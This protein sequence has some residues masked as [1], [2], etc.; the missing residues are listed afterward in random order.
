MIIG[1]TGKFCTGK[2]TAA[3]ILEEKGF[4]HLSLSDILREELT[5]QG[6]PITRD[7]LHALGD[8]LRAEHGAGVLAQRAIVRMHHGKN[9]VVTSIRNPG[10]VET[11]RKQPP[12][13]LICVDAPLEL[14]FKRLMERTDRK[15]DLSI[16]TPQDLELSERKEMESDPTKL[17]LHTVA[18]LADIVVHN[19][20]DLAHL[21]AQLERIITTNL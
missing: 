1:I 12:F 8:K 11:L 3:H 18:K 13:I 2:D 5:N 16:T 14:R 17:Q 6:I 20:K 9:Y 7:R 15:E 4:I 19:D 10:E 21:R